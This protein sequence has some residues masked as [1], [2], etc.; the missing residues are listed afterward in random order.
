M[1]RRVEVRVEPEGRL[2]VRFDYAPDLISEIKAIPGRSWSGCDRCWTIPAHTA[3]LALLVSRFR[4]EDLV[5]DARVERLLPSAGLEHAS[6]RRL[7]AEDRSLHDA[8]RAALKRRHDEL[9]VR[10]YSRHT[11]KAYVD[12]AKRFLTFA[13]T[14]PADLTNAQVREYMRMLL[15]DR[16]L[17][18]AYADQNVSALKF[19]FAR[20][21]GR[22]LEDLDIPRPKRQRKL[23]SVLSRGEVLAIFDAVENRKHRAILMMVYSAGLRVGEVVRLKIGDIDADRGMLHVRQA[24]GRKDRYVPLSKVGLEAV[25]RYLRYSPVSGPWLFPGQKQG[26]HLSERAVQHVFARAREKTGIT[27]PATVHTL[28]HSYATHLHESGIG[29]RYIQSLLGH[30]SPKTTEIYTH[31][32]TADLANVPSPLDQMM[33]PERGAD[34]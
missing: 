13:A 32:S 5:L 6:W 7:E 11:R 10:G 9:T 25:R 2:A 12:Q 22:P 8:N 19:L 33:D 31:V 30:R 23:P 27:K 3:A 16:G 4:E 15:E 1:P 21:L 20:A 29:L 24:K 17:S 26:R 34:E 18:H 28:R 14:P